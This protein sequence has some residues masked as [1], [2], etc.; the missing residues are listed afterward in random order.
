MARTVIDLNFAGIDCL[1][2]GDVRVRG[3]ACPTCGTKPDPRETDAKTNLRRRVAELALE[4]LA[5]PYPDQQPTAPLELLLAIWGE[6]ESWIGGF[7]AALRNSAD[8]AKGEVELLES[9]ER[10]RSTRAKLAAVPRRRPWMGLLS[11]L[12]ELLDKTELIAREYLGAFTAVR[13]IEAQQAARRGQAAIDTAAARIEPIS[14]RIARWT[15]IEGADTAEAVMAG[16]FAETYESTG[17]KDLGELDRAGQALVSRVTSSSECPDGTG[18]ALVLAD[19]QAQTALNEERFWAVVREVVQLFSRRP[20]RLR[21]AIQSPSWAADFVQSMESSYGAGVACQALLTAARRAHDDVRALLTLA[22]DLVEGLGKHLVATLL[23]VQGGP[24]YEKLRVRDAGALLRNAEQKGLG[25][26]IRG[27]DRT[28]RVARAHEEFRIQDEEVVLGGRKLPE[29]RLGMDELLDRVLTG[30]ESV[31]AIEVALRTAAAVHKVPVPDLQ[32]IDDLGLAP[33]DALRVAL[34]TAGWSDA[35]VL[36]EDRVIRV[37][38]RWDLNPRTVVGLVGL[39]LS[40]APIDVDSVEL[41]AESASDVV[42]CEGPL[43]A[44][45][46]REASADELERELYFVE[47]L[48]RWLFNDRPV[49]SAEHVQKLIAARANDAVR[50]PLGD[51]V[52]ELRILMAAAQRLNDNVL[53]EELRA[54]IRQMRCRD[55]GLPTDDATRAPIGRLAGR[56]LRNLAAPFTSEE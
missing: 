21:I 38:G 10:F 50:K 34:A 45:R 30:C 48:H 37:N 51:A 6:L 20:R 31:L 29:V 42:R 49:L 25:E 32:L 7:L 56:A 23:S 12:D 26:L 19:V 1:R 16:L 43:E 8:S 40:S 33:E 47:G 36:I 39:L 52:R 14:Q 35:T 11:E 44:F 41:I 53:E 4:R 24:D 54:C 17:A 13:P 18:I 46:N 5:A 9:I 55:L 2:C 27:L 22:L 28:M 3:L 15:R